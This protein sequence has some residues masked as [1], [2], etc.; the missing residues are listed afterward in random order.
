VTGQEFA[1]RIVRKGKAMEC[2]YLL[3]LLRVTSAQTLGLE[4]RLIRFRRLVSLIIP[5]ASYERIV[6]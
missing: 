2:L 5:K 4:K 1:F 6:N 3:Y